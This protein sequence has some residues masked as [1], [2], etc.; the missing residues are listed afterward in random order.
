MYVVCVGMAW[1]DRSCKSLSLHGRKS[2]LMG[3]C[4]IYWKYYQNLF[5]NCINSLFYFI[6]LKVY[7]QR[8]TELVLSYYSLKCNLF[9]Q[10]KSALKVVYC[11]VNVF[12]ITNNSSFISFTVSS[13]VFT[14]ILFVQYNSEKGLVK[15]SSCPTS[16]VFS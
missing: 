9:Y 3:F 15:S 6:K 10:L 4:N 16:H 13:L 11:S 7:M 14:A 12:R 8:F 5:P 2:C 1:G